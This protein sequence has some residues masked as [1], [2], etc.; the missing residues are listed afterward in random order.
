MTA[1]DDHNPRTP[2]GTSTLTH[3]CWV[4][5][6]PQP[7]DCSLEFHSRSEAEAQREAKEYASDHEVPAPGVRQL[8][9][10]C[11]IVTCGCGYLF[12]EDETMTEHFGDEKVAREYVT[13]SHWWS[14]DLRCP[15]CREAAGE[16][17]TAPVGVKR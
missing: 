12:D 14:G 6:V 2:G 4:L 11:H 10:P 15:G 3:C 8:V 1:T 16:S 17:L 13:G 9:E 5:D 7:L